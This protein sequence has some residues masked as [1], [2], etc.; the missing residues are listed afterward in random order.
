[1]AEN[2]GPLC[3]LAREVEE[4]ERIIRAIPAPIHRADLIE[5]IDQVAEQFRA[6]R[7]A[8]P[9][10]FRVQA[11]VRLFYGPMSTATDPISRPDEIDHA[12]LLHQ[13]LAMRI[14]LARHRTAVA[15][16]E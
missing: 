1:M 10:C 4:L 13:L 3:D 15:P 5:R 8:C 9:A 16:D 2:P 6:H 7:I 11:E 12:T 14:Q